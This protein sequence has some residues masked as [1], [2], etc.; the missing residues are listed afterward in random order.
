MATRANIKNILTPVLREVF[1]TKYDDYPEMYSKFFKLDTS[2]KNEEE[3]QT[4]SGLGVMNVKSESTPISYDDIEEAYKTTYT[5]ATYGLGFRASREAVEDE[6]YPVLKK[7]AAGL[8]RSARQTIEIRAAGTYNNG[9]NIA[10]PGA[11]AQP[12]LSDV[13]PLV[14]GGTY[15]NELAVAADLSVTSL[16]LAIQQ[17]MLTPDD[18]GL[19]LMLKPYLLVVPTQLM[20]T[21]EEIL[22]SNLRPDGASNAI[23]ALT[24]R[25][26]TPVV[27]P[28]LTNPKAWF[29]LDRDHAINFF[30]RRRPDFE[31]DNDFDTEDYKWKGTM[32]F[33][34]GWSDWR[35]IFGSPGT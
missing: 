15:N 24:N 3:D 11:D 27:Y 4:V 18:R 17:M 2:K 7:A 14:G 1:F 19:L 9:F 23:N 25:G 29:L 12:L 6:Q 13:H 16:Q 32:R 30:W 26:I 21:A 34:N 33:S 10:F 35:G 22:G 20:W 31:S 28:Y 8:A 5:H